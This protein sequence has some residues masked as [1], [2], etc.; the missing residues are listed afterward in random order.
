MDKLL[1]KKLGPLDVKALGDFFSVIFN[2]T[3]PKT[4]HPHLFNDQMAIT[5]CNEQK[6]L[7]C[8]I[9]LNNKIVGYGMLRGY[10]EGY[11]IP[12]LGVCIHPEY[13]NFKLGQLLMH[14]LHSQ[15]KL[16][17]SNKIRLKVYK[18]NLQAVHIYT[19]LGYILEDL[20]DKEL[21]GFKNL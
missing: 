4:F 15:A 13:S 14:Y 3:I 1:I 9:F 21:L 16:L 20:N 18:N 17:G 12:S 11:S 2:S 10:S 6:D 19:K 7:Y 8:S 5:I